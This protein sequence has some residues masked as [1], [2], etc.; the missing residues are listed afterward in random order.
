VVT[1]VFGGVGKV[2]PAVAEVFGGAGKTPVLAGVF[3]GYGNP[4]L[5]VPLDGGAY[6]VFYVRR[7]FFSVL[8]SSLFCI[9][10]ALLI[11]W[12]ALPLSLYV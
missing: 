2:D 1:G 3:G 9:S 7:G 11:S 5:N 10:E 12:T 8:D 4:P 6:N